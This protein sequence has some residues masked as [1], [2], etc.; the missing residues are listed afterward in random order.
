MFSTVTSDNRSYGL[1]FQARCV[2]A[3]QG[4]EE[5]YSR[6]L[7]G[8]LSLR[9]DNEIH[10]IQYAEN[11][12]DITCEGLY[13]H[14][15]EIWDLATCPYDSRLFS[16]VYAASGEFYAA[17]WRIPP[18]C[19]ESSTGGSPLLQQVAQLR[20][21]DAPLKCILWYPSGSYNQV[22]SLDQETIRLWDFDVEKSTVAL[23]GQASA[24]ELQQLSC[25][26]WDPHDVNRMAT[27]GDSTVHCWDLR[28]LERTWTI[29]HAHFMQV[30]DMDFNPKHENVL[31]T[32]GD[33]SKIRIWDLRSLGLPM[34][35]LSGH[36][37]WTWRARYNKFYDQLILT[38]GTD[39]VVN[40][41]HVPS[42]PSGSARQVRGRMEKVPQTVTESQKP[43]HAYTEHEDSV[44]GLAWSPKQP[45]MFASI[46]YDGRVMV[47]SV[48]PSVRQL[49][50]S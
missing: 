10:V 32:T 48:P 38:A 16:T 26:S 36:S 4:A 42:T 29:E 1:K 30:R 21:L 8:T 24:G 50:Q 37:H 18:K 33:D 6:F 46:S 28:A 31:M 43:V 17:I 22:V 45:W 34:L 5:D 7:V 35:E 49:V 9:E 23:K 44:Y 47:S 3:Q 20:G 13:S 41:W 19:S 25:G 11:N 27:A 12:S 15:H 2:A 39:T 14:P 40:L